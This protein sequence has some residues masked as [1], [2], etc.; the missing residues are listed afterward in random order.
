MHHALHQFLI[1]EIV[2]IEVMGINISFTNSS[3][4]MFVAIA[5]IMI[6]QLAG[7]RQAALVPGRFQS[8]VELSYEFIADMLKENVG[9]DGMQYFPLIFSVFMFILLSNL[10]GMLPYAFTVTSQIV[11]TFSLAMMIFITVTVIGFVK[12]GRKFFRTFFPEGAPLAVA[13]ILIPIE[14]ISY[15][16]RPLTLSIRLFANMLA[17]HVILKVFAGFAIT[18][19]IFGVAPLAINIAVTG[20]EFFVAAIQAYIFTILSCL[21]LHDALHMH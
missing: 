16:M 4:F 13:P 9:R 2:P 5:G 18:M 7:T 21:Y 15:F 12:N 17:G 19:G 8:M 6:F 11:V 10:L 3:L 1:K 20:F 14:I